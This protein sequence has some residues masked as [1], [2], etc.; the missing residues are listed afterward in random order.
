VNDL[1]KEDQ[2]GQVDDLH[3]Y[4]KATREL[5]HDKK[6]TRTLA[7]RKRARSEKPWFAQAIIEQVYF[8]VDCAVHR[9]YGVFIHSG[10]I[11]CPYRVTDAHA[12][13]CWA[14]GMCNVRWIHVVPQPTLFLCICLSRWS[15]D[16]LM[17]PSSCAKAR[18]WM[19][20]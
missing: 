20:L 13:N 7:K 1:G 17:E 14:I 5:M 15:V 11:I 10:S 3:R 18:K 16:S 12:P 8:P 6:G 9:Y 4:T 19:P 2:Q